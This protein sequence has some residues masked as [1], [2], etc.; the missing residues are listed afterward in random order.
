MSLFVP[1]IA[2]GQSW[3]EAKATYQRAVTTGVRVNLGVDWSTYDK[4]FSECVTV[5]Q[6]AELTRLWTLGQDGSYSDLVLPGIGAYIRIYDTLIREAKT[7][8]ERIKWLK[9]MT[10]SLSIIYIGL[11]G[12]KVKGSFKNADLQAPYNQ[13]ARIEKDIELL[14]GISV[15]LYQRILDSMTG[16]L[17][18]ALAHAIP[19]SEGEF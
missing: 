14:G 3:S 16:D 5:E 19:L 1:A 6:K 11:I 17:V 2:S 13:L 8:K 12:Q 9:D 4:W 18:T 7:D 15:G 10:E